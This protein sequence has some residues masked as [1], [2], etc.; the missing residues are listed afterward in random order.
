MVAI[1]DHAVSSHARAVAVLLLTALLAFLPGFFQ[2]PPTDRDEARFAQA[3]K[4]MLETGDFIDIRFQDEVR[5]KKPVGIYWLQAATVKTAEWLGVPDAHK[6]VWLYRLPSL[7]GAIGAVLL[8]YWTALVFVSRR[9]AVLAGMMLATSVLLGVEARLAKT[10]AMLLFTIVAAMGTMARAYL[11]ERRPGAIGP[12]GWT[13]PAIFWTAI[14]A[15]I[16]LKGPLIVMVVALAAIALVVM[17]RSAR[18]MLALRPLTG[19]AWA[20]ILVAPWFI[21]ILDRAGNSF[22]AESV[23]RDLAA[24]VFTGQEAHGA[25]PG[26]YFALFWLSFWPAATLAGMAV[27]SVWAARREKGAR[28]LLA[29]IVPSWIVFELVVTKLPHYVLPV[30]PAVAILIA[31]VVDQHLL[32]RRIWLLRGAVWWFVLPVAG[33]DRR[34]R[35]PDR[36]RPPAWPGGVAVCRRCL[37]VRPVG[38]AAVPGR[39]RRAFAAARH[40]GV[41]PDGLRSLWRIFSVLDGGVP[42]RGARPHAG[43]VRL[44]AAAGRRRRLS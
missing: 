19:L 11:G 7:A 15:G 40:A 42:E 35:R 12:S 5:Y 41:D 14:A 37:G 2:I 33:V 18:W 23:G 20:A 26:T 28:F 36:V 16:L 17:D 38:L 39:W 22:L 34:R 9:A 13:V 30:Y 1:V 32:T 43:R 25:P 4:Q 10:D 21:A 27:P 31:G 3:S 8:T 24:K 29:W 6:T 44:Q